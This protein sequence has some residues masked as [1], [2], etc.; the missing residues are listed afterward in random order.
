MGLF[1]KKECDVCGG[2]IGLLGNRKLEDG[3]MCKDCAC[4]LSPFMTDRRR[5]TLADIKEHLAYREANKAEVEA[6]N[7]TRTLGDKTK[8]L[9]DEDAKKFIVTSSSRWKSDNP[10]VMAFSQVTGCNTEIREDKTELKTKD[11]EGKSISYSPPRYRYDYDFYVT[12]HVNSQWFNDIRFQLNRSSIEHRGSVE[13]RNFELQANEIKAS[14]MQM[15]QDTRES[16]AA[17][18][19]PKVAQT[20]PYCG[21]TTTPDADGR[22]EYCGGAM[23]A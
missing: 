8:V 4:L 5:T 1:S 13:Y 21:A 22:C 12:V 17:A 3:N 11:K 9:L 6:F 19:A 7:V 18:Q 16:A 23:Q 14:L 20:C 2:K 15:R 10:D